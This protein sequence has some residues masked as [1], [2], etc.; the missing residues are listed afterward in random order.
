MPS[1]NLTIE[2][3]LP[4]P[5]LALTLTPFPSC[6]VCDGEGV[7]LQEIDIEVEYSHY[8]ACRGARDRYGAQLEPDDA[9]GLE[10]ESVLDT[11]GCEVALTERE[12]SLAESA[13]IEQ[14][15]DDRIAALEA[16]AEARADDLRC[17]DSL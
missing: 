5:C 3:D 17:Y 1:I 11:R 14:V 4:C 9:E 13:A 2:R 15:A 16:R 6:P 7:A 12:N 10:I 8:S